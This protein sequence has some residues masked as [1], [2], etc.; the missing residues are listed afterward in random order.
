M[1]QETPGAPL[2]Q[3]PAQAPWRHRAAP[4]QPGSPFVRLWELGPAAAA[5]AHRLAGEQKSATDL[6]APFSR[7]LRQPEAKPQRPTGPGEAGSGQTAG[8]TPRTRERRP[9]RRQQPAPPSPREQPPRHP[10]AHTPGAG[11]APHTHGAPDTLC[12][13]HAL[14]PQSRAHAEP[15]RERTDTLL[16]HLQVT[17]PAHAHHEWRRSP[18]ALSPRPRPP[19]PMLPRRLAEVLWVGAQGWV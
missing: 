5:R 7:V 4:P 10:A 1:A 16:A 14:S 17:R 8:E 3:G 6:R 12:M 13:Q 2:S 18:G 9:D 15:P 19:H 11:R